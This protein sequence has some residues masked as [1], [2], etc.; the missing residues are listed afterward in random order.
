MQITRSNGTLQTLDDLTNDE[1]D[2]LH[3]EEEREFARRIAAASKGSSDRAEAFRDG[4]D[5]VTTI[6][7]KR[8]GETSSGLVMG[9]NPRYVNLVLRLL[10]GYQQ[11]GVQTPRMFEV[12]YGSG[13]M[14]ASV[15]DEGFGVAG[16]EVSTRMRDQALRRLPAEMHAGVYLGDFLSLDLGKENGSYHVAYWNDVFEHLPPDESLDFLRKLHDLLAP[17][18]TLLTITPNWH[19]RPGDITGLYHP[20]RTEAE[21]FHLREYTLREM[22]RLLKAAGFAKVSTP[23]FVT[24]SQTVLCG[25]GLCGPKRLIEPLF[26]LLPYKLTRLL[27]RGFAMSCTLAVKQG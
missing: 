2:H 14:L 10:R 1:L 4:Y 5:T 17:G 25:G 8:Y 24:H 27:C 13:A 6:I 3:W 23:L 9:L 21:G 15:A 11:R 20:P 22:V 16:I 26:E 12:G 18:G 7:A 19:L